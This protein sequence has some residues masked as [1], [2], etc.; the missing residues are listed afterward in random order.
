[1]LGPGAVPAGAERERPR[2][3]TRAGEGA[4]HGGGAAQ[5]SGSAPRRRTSLAT[6]LKQDQRTAAPRVVPATGPAADSGA[7]DMLPPVATPIRPPPS[8]S[9]EVPAR[10][11]YGPP[12]ALPRLFPLP[13]ASARLLRASSSS[14]SAL[15]SPGA[16]AHDTQAPRAAAAVAAGPPERLDESLESL[17]YLRRRHAERQL[18]RVDRGQPGMPRGGSHRSSSPMAPLPTE[19]ALAPQVM[20]MSPTL[21][22]RRYEPYELKARARTR[23]GRLALPAR[24]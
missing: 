21:G 18:G 12:S 20:F 22:R 13:P 23:C 2:P 19:E 11:A 4:A 16:A 7:R 17:I 5:T 14:A 6:A 8:T 10:L 3:Q 9:V 1:M 24:A 15:S